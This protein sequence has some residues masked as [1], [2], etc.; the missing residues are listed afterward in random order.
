MII[1][2]AKCGE[3]HDSAV[4][5]F[6]GDVIKPLLEI[7]DTRAH[8]DMATGSFVCNRCSSTNHVTVNC[9]VIK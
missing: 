5:P 9:V 8:Q 7:T 6:L 4:T 1:Q 3:V 2:C